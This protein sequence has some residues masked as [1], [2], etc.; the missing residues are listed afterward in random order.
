VV[1]SRFAV[2]HEILISCKCI[3]IKKCIS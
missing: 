3:H 1:R 2:C